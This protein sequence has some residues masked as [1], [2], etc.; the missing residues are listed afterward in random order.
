MA[1]GKNGGRYMY[2]WLNREMVE[3]EEG[4]W[5]HGSWKGRQV[6]VMIDVYGKGCGLGRAG[7]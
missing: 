2:V 4:N 3:V 6:C 1:S 5:K 7:N